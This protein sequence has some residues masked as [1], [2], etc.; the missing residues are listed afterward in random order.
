MRTVITKKSIGISWDDQQIQACVIRRGIAEFAIDKL[1]RMDRE[2]GTAGTPKHAIAEDLKILARHIGYE[3]DVSVFGLP[4]SE[5]MYRTLTRPFSDRKK[6]ADTIGS[7]VETLLPSLDSP[8][9]VDFVILGKDQAENNRIQALCTRFPGVIN[10]LSNF[11]ES[12]FDPDIIDCPS[13]AIAGGARTLLDLP[14]GK[15]VV[16][17][18]M[19]WKETSIAVL[20]DN[21]LSWV[22]SLPFGFET[23][24]TSA[25]SEQGLTRKLVL[26]K[27]KILKMPAGD[28]LMPFFRELLIM[29]DKN[30]NMKNESVLVAT[31]YARL[32]SDLEAKSE[33][34]LGMP[35]FVPPLKDV[36]FEG[37]QQDLFYGFLSAAL[38]CRAFDAVDP[39]NFR[40]G[41]LGV[42]KRIKM[43]KGYAGTWIKAA[44]ILL[45]IWIAGLVLDVSLKAH[46]N[47][48]LTNKIQTEFVSVMPKNTPIYD[49]PAKQMEQHFKKLTD[50]TG[51]VQGSDTPLE[52]LRDLSAGIPASMDVSFDSINIDENN[53]TLTGTTSS[54]D[55]VN[56]IKKILSG[57][58]YVKEVKD[59][60]AI[61]EKSDQKVK[62]KLVCKK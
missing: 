50:Q 49:D 12:S 60:S 55:K 61:G 29:L 14:S 53:I 9:L 19:G 28:K 25:V 15:N 17:L 36:H 30:G 2:Q 8:L 33:E 39:V 38:A 20:A 54:Y 45:L 6:I 58:P 22:G 11:K 40:Q 46:I 5:I 43:M 59:L 35:L 10:I 3:V 7:E 56:S 21:E 23:I 13:V 16:L 52:F 41:E 62:L 44:A 24:V 47:K 34:A 32:I 42:S 1:I 37:S 4:E 26:D 57:L 51:S 27:A 48:S 31:G 18:H